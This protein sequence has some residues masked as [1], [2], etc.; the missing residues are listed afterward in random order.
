MK[1]IK[2][3]IAASEELHAEKLEFTNLIEHLNQVLKPRGIE[4]KRVKWNSE[5]DGP[6][7]IYK[8]KLRDCEMCLNLYWRNLSSNSE[9][10]LNTAYQQLKDGNNPRN[11]YVFFKEPTENLTEE[12]RD[13]KANFVTNYGH[14]FC[15][16]ENVDT[17]NLHFVLQF[18]AYQ[19]RLGDQEERFIEVS[20]GKV[21]VGEINIANLDNIP[22]AGLNKEYCRLQSEKYR[23]EKDLMAMHTHFKADPDN[24]DLLNQ[25]TFINN[26]FN[27][28]KK[29]YNR[30]Q[31]Y[32]LDIA[33][34]LAKNAN[35][36]CTQ[37]M[38]DAQKLFEQGDAINAAK[39]LSIDI[40][41]EN[42]NQ[43]R[44]RWKLEHD[45][46]VLEIEEFLLSAKYVMGN[47]DISMQERFESASIAY[48]E[49]LETA[50]EIAYAPEKIAKIHFDYANLQVIFKK[51]ENA[52]SHFKNILILI[53]QKHHKDGYLD[54]A[55]IAVVL[56]NMADLQRVLFRY[57]DAKKSILRSIKIY[58]QLSKLDDK[59]LPNLAVALRTL[60][61]VDL[62]LCT[63]E[64]AEKNYLKS[65]DIY[66]YLIAVDYEAHIS[67]MADSL[68]SL[69]NIQIYLNKVTQAES[70]LKLALVIYKSMADI[71]STRYLPN[72]AMTLFDLAKLQ[73]IAGR[74]NEAEIN[75]TNSLD[76]RRD[77]SKENPEIFL[78]DVSET[79]ND[80]AILKIGMEC[81][82]EAEKFLKEALSIYQRLIV[83]F[84]IVYSP[85]YV[86]LYHNLL[87]LRSAY[88]LNTIDEE[89]ENFYKALKKCRSYYKDVKP[90]LLSDL[91][92]T[93]KYY[94][95]MKFKEGIYDDVI[96][97]FYLD[98]P[99]DKETHNSKRIRA[100][101]N[102][103]ID[104]FSERLRDYD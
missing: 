24:V 102:A 59:Y 91:E 67:G 31:N 48:E 29:E 51:Y 88:N 38:F 62:D 11:L 79:L 34:Q 30:Y 33:L 86:I 73:R 3:L 98:A 85:N 65:L 46:R 63:Y 99:N 44:A 97:A 16:F 10:E 61:D 93:H 104:L 32:L 1:T 6:I 101:R 69:A 68:D 22:F 100:K 83:V 15:K 92:K 47:T 60:A 40:L 26:K 74:Y 87:V 75:Y 96:G 76:I 94:S 50:A 81:F 36:Q 90:S 52:L 84:P 43:N 7:E 37:R 71:N 4:L 56:N 19:N 27:E 57:N 9:E 80:L 64:N 8:A 66:K 42:K 12:L 70:N 25:L 20:D 21:K 103:Y 17:M 39:L 78:H 35:E 55:I 95:L 53:K 23:I 14:F 41:K 28:V 13:F 77:L 2:I 89:K 72:V 5:N 82:G 54:S 58:R 45:R 49:A 18:E